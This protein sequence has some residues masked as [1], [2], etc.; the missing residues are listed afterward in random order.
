MRKIPK[1]KRD[2]FIFISNL[3]DITA[4][5]DHPISLKRDGYLLSEHYTTT[6]LKKKAQWVKQRRNLL[7]SDNGNFTRM[8]AIASQFDASELLHTAL[9]EDQWGAVSLR[10]Q[11]RRDVM[12]KEIASAC[13]E[14]LEKTDFSKIIDIQVSISP[15]YLIGLEDFTIPVLMLCGLMHPVFKPKANSINSYQKRTIQ[16]F[17]DQM[18]GTYGNREVLEKSN[19][20]LVLHAYDYSSAFQGGKGLR[21]V[22][23]SGIAISYGGPMKSRRWITSVAF[24]DHIEKFDEKLP[25][26]YLIATAITLGASKGVNTPIPFHI[27]GVGSP[28]LVALI[29]CMLKS[30]KAISIDSTA[31]FKDSN[32][33]K[34]YGSKKAFLKMDMYKVAA[35][36]LIDNKP[37]TS[38]TPFFKRFEAD[39]PSDWQ[40]LRNKLKVTEQTNAKALTKQLKENLELIEQYIPF[41]SKMRSGNSPMIDQLR[42]DRA[43]HNYWILRN[44]CVSIRKRMDNPEKMNQ[45]MAYQ[46]HRYKAV[47]NRK[48]SK[49]IEISFEFCK[50]YG[51]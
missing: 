29:G 32:A 39:Y 27:L 17:S 36:A 30:S 43:G 25:E 18:A 20:F 9:E 14:A 21:E 3:G 44:I 49:A 5:S 13:K 37:F 7:I 28:I 31:P 12:M 2:S 48:W 10:T 42:I 15:D 16:L 26:A 24:N 8:K 19:N 34:L 40:G 6:V 22:S 47:A 23:P 33:G 51:Q 46:V 35:Y 50:K 4:H 41:F 11:E 38:R 1:L 45:W